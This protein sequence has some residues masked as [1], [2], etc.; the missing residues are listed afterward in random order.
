MK[1]AISKAAVLIEAMPYIQEFRDKIVVIKFGGSAMSDGE[2]TRNVLRDIVLM[3]LV[4]MRPVL[5]HGGGSAIS[6]EMKKKGKKPVFA[7]GLRVTDGETIK[8]VQ[9]TLFEVVNKKL[10]KIIAEF[11]GM[12][13]SLSG[14]KDKIIEAKKKKVFDPWNPE[15]EI[16]MGFAGDVEK[17][18]VARLKDICSDGK[19]PVIAPLGYNKKDETFNVN[20]DHAA[21]EIAAAL[22]AEKMVF[23]TNV[24][25]IMGKREDKEDYLIPSITVKEIEKLK[26]K[27]VITGGMLPKVESCVHAVKSG[28]HKTHIIDAK[29]QHSLLLEIFTD[30]GIGTEILV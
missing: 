14:E 20:A 1:E 2:I 29:I 8:I 11:G 10:V 26:Q 19:I 23:L 22:K 4:G 6:E 24:K 9:K 28:V 27:K 17:A 16:D 18:H 12:A 21:A 15:K 3:E 25:G 30:K 7:H 5:I 13:E